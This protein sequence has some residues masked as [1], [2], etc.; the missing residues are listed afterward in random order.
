MNWLNGIIH[1]R[2]RDNAASDMMAERRACDLAVS[3]IL[4]SAGHE[5][6]GASIPLSGKDA[7]SRAPAERLTFI[8]TAVD[9]DD[10]AD[11]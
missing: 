5:R 6:A 11:F 3:T 1:G 9:A 7:C 4:E 10:H 2:S 8:L